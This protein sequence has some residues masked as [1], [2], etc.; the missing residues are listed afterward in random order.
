M[1]FSDDGSDSSVSLVGNEVDDV[2]QSSDSMSQLLVNVDPLAVQI[3]QPAIA[4]GS[5]DVVVDNT[6]YQVDTFYEWMTTA[7]SYLKFSWDKTIEPFAVYGLLPLLEICGA[8]MGC[9]VGNTA[10][11]GCGHSLSQ[12]QR[13]RKFVSRLNEENGFSIRKVYPNDCA[14]VHLRGEPFNSAH[15]SLI[16]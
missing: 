4:D 14:E 12:L 6:R 16:V 15:H 5:P 3:L 13:I 7:L 2:E 8:D 10:I 9:S 1:S 11:V